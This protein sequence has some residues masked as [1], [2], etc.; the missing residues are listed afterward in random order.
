MYSRFGF[1]A[2]IVALVASLAYGVPQILQVMGILV[3]PWDRI[4]IFLPSLILAPAFVLTM[5]AVHDAAPTAHRVWTTGALAIAVMYGTMVSIVYVVQLG[6]VIPH[7]IRGEGADF[8]LFACCGFGQPLTM[9]DLLGYTLMSLSTLLAA[10]AFRNAG[11]EA[12]A[13]FWLIA[14]G[15]L[16]PFL[17]AQIAYPALIY[18]GALWLITFPLAMVCVALVFRRRTPTRLELDTGLLNAR[19]EVRRDA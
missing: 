2:A 3:D 18:V 5:A 12:A 8:R 9:I 10:P 7:D 14:N 13:R 1:W 6:S 4:L 19:I 17:I 15:V 11:L 16:A